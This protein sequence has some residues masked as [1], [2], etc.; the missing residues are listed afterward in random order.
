[1]APG[2][3]VLVWTGPFGLFWGPTV[4]PMSDP[5]GNCADNC[6][7][8]NGGIM[9]FG[10]SSVMRA[11]R[12]VV[13]L[14]LASLVATAL[15]AAAA[16]SQD[17]PEE[18]VLV[19]SS[20][21]DNTWYDGSGD[22]GA[23]V[24]TYGHIGCEQ[25]DAQG[26][27]TSG[28]WGRVPDAPWIWRSK[29]SDRA[30]PRATFTDAFSVDATQAARPAVLDIAADNV[31]EVRLNDAVV[32]SGSSYTQ[33]TTVE[34]QLADGANQLEIDVENI[35]NGQS[36]Y[37]NPA[38]VAWAIRAVK[39][40][41]VTPPAHPFQPPTADA[42]PDQSVDEG[43]T[44]SLDGSGSKA[45][46][47]PALESS[48][49]RGSLPGG[50]SLGAALDE[51][52]GEPTAL[53]VNG[54]VDVG[55]GAAAQNTSIAYVVD[56]SG[57]AGGRGGPCGNVNGDRAV[58]TILDCELAAA[59]K[60]HEEVAASGTVD[61]VALI[62][63]SSSAQAVDLDPT[64]AVATLVGPTTDA[65]GDGVADIV[66]AIKRVSGSGGTNFLPPVKTACNLLATTGSPNLV[67]AF[68]S[69]GQG[70]G[71][72][73]TALPCDPPV[74]FHAFA[75][76]SGSKCDSGSAVGSRL[77]DMATLS[78]GTCTNVPVVSDL[79]EI[80]PNVISSRITKVS[81]TVDGGDPVDISS[82]LD[83]P[84]AGPAALDVSFEL[85]AD[86]ASGQHRICL[87]VT[88][89]DS[90]GT[91][92]ETTCSELVTVTG[93]VTYAWRQVSRTGPPV[94]LS[95]RTSAHPSFVAADDG[96]YVFEL[97]VT[98][99]TGSVATD[100]VV[101][102]VGNVAPGLDL[103]H[104]DSFAGGV[105]QVNAT[106]TDVGWLDSHSATV[107]W[108]D[109]TVDTVEVTTAGPGWGTFFGSH[110]Y[111]TAGSY[112]VVVELSD[113]D[114]GR[115]VQRVDH[116]EVAMPAAVWANS[117]V[118]PSLN[119]AGGSGEI[120]G[121]IHTN[122]QLRFVGAAKAVRGDTTYA[123]SLA[124]D[125]TK[126]SFVPLPVK[127]GV[128]DF[129]ISPDVADFRPGGPVAVEVG[130]AYH[131]MS[132][133]CAS[134]SWHEVQAALESGVYYAP[135]D[136]QLN[137]SDIG[138]RVTL[139]SEGRVKVAGSR[140]A[141][142][143]YR[144]GLLVLAGASGAKAIDVATSSSKFL[145]VIFAGSGEISVSGAGNRFYCGIL[146]DT[147]SITGTDVNVRGA[148][149]GRPSSTVSGPV[150]VPDLRAGITVDRTEALPSDEL[151]Y[152]LTVSNG[153]TTVVVP[154]LIGLENVDSATATVRGFEF[155]VERQE[156]DS[157]RWVPVAAAGDDTM[158]LSLRPNPFPGVTYAGQTVVGTAVAPSGW[159]TWGAQA[160]LTLTPAQTAELLDEART[161]GVRTRV[162]F[163]LD[164]STVQARRLYTFG[165]DFGP[166]L[167]E[168]GAD[169]VD[170]S[171]TAILPDGEATT[172]A[173][174]DASPA[175]LAAGDSATVHRTWT[176]PVPAARA[177]TET[178]AGYLSRI[179]ALDGTPLTGA[180]FVTAEGGIGRLV[181]PLARAV[182]H[183]RLP[184]VEV[185]A[186]GADA[187]AAGSSAEYDV[188]LGNVGSADAS[189]VEVAATADAVDLGVTGAPDALAAGERA[190]ARTTYAAP[191]GSSGTMV[192]RGTA[193]WQD[194]RG[195]TYGASGTTLPVV[196]QLPADLLA[197][198]DDSLLRDLDGDAAVSPGDTVRYALTVRNRGGQPLTGVAGNLPVPAH[199][200]VAPDAVSAPDGGSTQ[201]A[202]GI[203][204]F[205][206]PDLA[207]GTSRRVF[208]DAVV[209][210]PFPDGVSRLSAQAVVTGAG[211]GEVLSDDPALPGSA[212]PTRTT[213]VRPQPALVAA[214]T[215]Q[216][217]VDADGSG[218][219]TPGDTL[220]YTLGISSV[221]NKQVTG[222]RAKVPTPTATTL[223]AGSIRT[224]DGEVLAGS[225]VEVL[226]GTLA[227][228]Q[229]ATIEF[230]ARIDAALPTGVRTISASGTVTSDQL[231]PLHTDD[232][233]T[234]DVGDGTAIPI[235]DDGA[236]TDVPSASVSALEPADG[237]R[238]ATPTDLSATVTVP[239]GATIAT[240]RVE[241]APA[242]GGETTVLASGQ[243]SG[244]SVDVAAQID[245]T[246]LENGLYVIRIVSVTSDGAR[247]VNTSSVLVDGGFKPG[248]MA[249]SFVD[250]ELTLSGLPVQVRRSYDSFD[251]GAG[252]FG[253]GWQVDI[254]DFRIARA[255][256]LGRS[257]W[258]ARSTTCGLIFC[259]L[260]YTSS[261]PHMV[262]VVW[263][264]GRQEVFDLKGVD[265]S[266]FFPGIARAAFVPRPGTATTSKLEVVGDDSVF[267][268]AGDL[269]GGA[270]GTD[271]VFDP[272][273]F[274][275]TDRAGT[276]YVLDRASGLRSMA[277]R[278]GNTLTFTADGV[279]SSQGTDI[280]FTRDGSGRLTRIAS[281][282][283][284]T[285]YAYDHGNLVSSR[286][287][288]GE[289]TRYE[290]DGA[291]NLTNVVGPGGRS[292]GS[293]VYDADGR[294][295][296]WVDAE[297]N[298]TDIATDLAANQERI[299]SADGKLLTISTFDDRGVLARVNEV[300]S[301]ADH[302]TAY[303]YDANLNVTE[304]T[305]PLGHHW[306]AAYDDKGN[307]T[308][309][310]APG[311]GA[312]QIAY[313]T[314]N[315]P[316]KITDGTGK[317]SR[318][319]W[320]ET[321]G[322]LTSV[323]DPTGESVTFGY[324]DR[325]RRTSRT[326]ALGHRT[327]WTYDSAGRVASE[328]DPLGRITSWTYD[329][330]GRVLTETDALGGVT[331]HTYDDLGNR[332]S[333]T[334]SEGRTERWAYDALSRMVRH[335]DARGHAT[336]YN[337]DGMGRV[338]R[339]D[340]HVDLATNYTYDA[341]GRLTSTSSGDIV[342]ERLSWDGG[343]NVT[344]RIDALGNVTSYGYDALGRQISETNPAGGTTR[345]RYTPAGRV[346]ATVAAWGGATT[347]DHDAAGREISRTDPAG[348]VWRTVYDAVGRP[349]ESIAPDGTSTKARY[350]A[351]GRLVA[352]I[353][354]AG[355][356]TSYE[357][358]AA[359]QV[360]ATVDAEGRRSTTTYDDL[361]RSVSVTG[362]DGES[363]RTAFS[364][365]GLVKSQTTPSG[366]TTRFTHDDAGAVVS[367]TDPM[368]HQW[369][370]T[371]DAL[372]RVLTERDPRDAGTGPPTLTHAY[373]AYGRLAST[374]DALAGTVRFGYDA[375]SQRT[376]VTDARGKVWRTEFGP[377]GLPVSTT[378][379]LGRETA[380]AYDR[381]GRVLGTTDARGLSAAYEYDQGG[382]VASVS[383][384]GGTGRVAWEYDA[385]GRR[386]R[387]EDGSGTTT[388][389]YTPTGLV[390]RVGS[391]QGDVTYDYD[392]T[393]LRTRMTQ[394][395]GTI[396]YGYDEAG[397]PARMT[398]L[399]GGVST[400]TYTADGD[401][402]SVIRPNGVVSTW[403][404]DEAGRVTGV[405]HADADG[406]TVSKAT[407]TLDADGNRTS[408][409]TLRGTWSF[410]LDAVDQLVSQTS[411]DGEV[412]RWT[413]DA[414]GNRTSQ[415]R[416]GGQ[417]IEY[418]YDDAGQLTAVGGVSLT[419]DAA[420]HVTSVGRG[421]G[422]SDTYTWD[423]RGRLRRAATTTA[424][425]VA[426]EAVYGYN[427]DGL[428]VT[429]RHR[430]ADGQL[431]DATQRLYDTQAGGVPRLVSYGD[432]AY[433]YDPSG[434]VAEVR[435]G[436][437]SL[438]PLTDV[439]GSVTAVTDGSGGAVAEVDYDAFGTAQ[440]LAGAAPG[441]G[442]TG[443][444]ATA[445]GL[446][447]LQARDYDPTTGRF[448]AKDPVTPGAPGVVG[449]NPY[450]Y[451]ANN[452]TTMTDPSGQV[453][454]VERAI[455][456][457]P[458]IAA[459]S[460][461]YVLG[462]G[463]MFLYTVGAALTHCIAIRCIAAPD[464]NVDLDSLGGGGGSQ[465]ATPDELV[466]ASESIIKAAVAAG[467][468]T[469]VA[470]AI[471]RTCIAQ[472]TAG[473]LTAE[474]CKREGGL[475]LF[476][477]GSLDMPDHFAHV[478]IAFAHGHP[479][480][481]HRKFPPN[482]RGW[483][484]SQPTCQEARARGQ[485]CDEYPFASTM[486][487]G[488]KPAVFFG[489]EQDVVDMEGERL[490]SV[491]GVDSR[492][493]SIQGGRLGG[494]Y[495]KC[496]VS[497]GG[498]AFAVL[499]VPASPT[500]GICRG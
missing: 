58:D 201:L 455:I 272:T 367:V 331:T 435:A 396:T 153:G 191:T 54:S 69:D 332:T 463:V 451:V 84:K 372:G 86:L 320:D 395:E 99:G 482:S 214:L 92:S 33:G 110:V 180:M 264:D 213:V 239:S 216:L 362:P 252:D 460:S 257:G 337:H 185:A 172:F 344:E 47:K 11:Y 466:A 324:D 97:T 488:R 312:A 353:D 152:D 333:T 207:G 321:R 2:P 65:D 95:A 245:P 55:E 304:R 133:A 423:W 226:V 429:E 351:M 184:I 228:F 296:A 206:L 457:Y 221:G 412:T 159:A 225:G 314:L 494:F 144:D 182:T 434:S 413:Y 37:L 364:P 76:G 169:V 181:A 148:D 124:A 426:A 143:P 278:N 123:G 310:T 437:A 193:T 483:L 197:T 135:C 24:L 326:D 456:S 146:G 354:Q 91:S 192:L 432:E 38:G 449:W 52:E 205:T 140:P 149:C 350:D 275:L 154:S 138:G 189:N 270:F 42:G 394:P 78:G 151:G 334:D 289:E 36:P 307:L 292:L 297:G 250:H 186:E 329:A 74:T 305:D 404:R 204:S 248:R 57:S 16:V 493:S 109:G 299:T 1:M 379:P 10:V 392:A 103:R 128:Q 481:L 243:G 415:A 318:L 116:L 112:D 106:L 335:I 346:A 145:G 447:H 219:V 475:P 155:V 134:G 80:L 30:K 12:Y 322:T 370:A 266:T 414:A 421:G 471:G 402:A 484:D 67:T 486:E 355:G 131:D 81:Y 443:A 385:Q 286:D 497:G 87:T 374:T 102:E 202:D 251:T 179:Q 104:G 233:Q 142:E 390:S 302:V 397:R 393:G 263:P 368:G 210:Q 77:I 491:M 317:T 129:P 240:W 499:P 173:A 433:T 218:T 498:G 190:T 407:Y 23:A 411:P 31:F 111:R 3:S 45:S 410:E 341:L 25:V 93:E 171:V 162:D 51:L 8:F 369:S 452:P 469:A 126:N 64:S 130:A 39:P 446:V 371:Y 15:P 83:L 303:T 96:R 416:E 301:G 220:A 425:G 461:I 405:Q 6:S 349:V 113:D 445:G 141:F 417:R 108:G 365:S 309:F 242:D 79:P 41:Q 198:L 244:P 259:S 237:A 60:L 203:V 273:T 166:V 339:I 188:E 160:V 271:G 46:T 223:V 167:R 49:Q 100:Q 7:A 175:R 382:R 18:L 283:G 361:G 127:T 441:L 398:G 386:I 282:V 222:I 325:G 327:T 378:D 44:V 231:E 492:E 246:L 363:W 72:L 315:V 495:T 200:T 428:R 376:S 419:H 403:S 17:A 21:P 249:T 485:A 234:V 29:D 431:A 34:I 352:S 358:D 117:T 194:A 150:V 256:P 389:A 465:A 238:V 293:N 458:V 217:A 164:P 27:C 75:V 375:N 115:A 342:R 229:A 496:G 262:S 388:T 500:F 384:V 284:E 487:G 473:R 454:L 258:S 88:G 489:N 174:S 14:I 476:I 241:I 122:G 114:G 227:P 22:S 59:L 316:V 436:A 409:T 139:V 280:A 73:K 399:G 235:G 468:T 459:G 107:D 90:G 165:T 462:A 373:D 163:V 255:T 101:V 94:F 281:P 391:P 211:Q 20:G 347:F 35:D 440:V 291:H 50:T 66:Q 98:D 287:L 311:E 68:M 348:E 480:R 82:S 212:D 261:V 276:S 158:R 290:Y 442:Y 285:T 147:V 357:L 253:V 254:A 137:G 328:T 183:R 298:R 336:D 19:S 377:L 359:G 464:I 61:K 340:N 105:T 472:V 157:G 170:A 247:S 470:K 5:V 420:G 9:S 208:V 313:N 4:V 490:P 176:V 274:R 232:P 62:T 294:L 300:H 279:R 381:S 424:D 453:A 236:S 330:A 323:T 450:A 345:V 478:G 230:R 448:L 85:P 268:S 387:M 265:G 177:A 119:W 295:V 366:A 467:V 13:A 132:A 408:R 187:V 48:E 40:G 161:T 209:A 269:R 439:Q 277:D 401:V 53:R 71:S 215:G 430:G 406:S 168:L 26:M 427:G 195:N 125:T 380:T 121:R 288:A 400:T 32:A 267:F 43:S 199:V 63:F 56:V 418:S 308:S 136:I 338:V 196:R 178:D 479:S 156:A 477:V 438:V 360:V 343:G 120:Q 474:E 319:A 224:T 70:S 260:E 383:E 89:E 444:P 118:S 306:K 422:R 28:L 356:E